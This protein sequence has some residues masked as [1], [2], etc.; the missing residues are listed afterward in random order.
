MNSES[1][2][3]LQ[4]SVVQ[5]DPHRGPQMAQALPGGALPTCR[6]AGRGPSR[7]RSPDVCLCSALVPPQ[8]TSL[9]SGPGEA[10]GEPG[11][12]GRA[13]CSAVVP[14]GWERPCL[15]LH[16]ASSRGLAHVKE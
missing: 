11:S 12:A 7:T 6:A 5:G 4:K 1:T 13:L 10:T 3:S 2:K 16:Q 8:I 14:R 15:G 9:P